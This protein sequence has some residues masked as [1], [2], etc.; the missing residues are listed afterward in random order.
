MSKISTLPSPSVVLFSVLILRSL[1]KFVSP[2]NP[3]CFMFAV[4]AFSSKQQAHRCVRFCSA[5]G[6]IAEILP[7]NRHFDGVAQVRTD[8]KFESLVYGAFGS[9]I[10]SCLVYD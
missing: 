10:S 5:S 7:K 3:F 2:F 9:F 8:S 6:I 1:N 4:F